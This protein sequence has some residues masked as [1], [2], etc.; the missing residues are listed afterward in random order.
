MTDDFFSS[1]NLFHENFLEIFSQI[2]YGADE[3]N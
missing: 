1:L 3:A 2:V